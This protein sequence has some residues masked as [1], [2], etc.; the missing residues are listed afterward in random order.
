MT[1]SESLASR[2]AKIWGVLGGR[3]AKTARVTHV[4]AMAKR[5][6]NLMALKS[7]RRYKKVG[8]RKPFQF[9]GMTVSG[10]KVQVIQQKGKA[11]SI[12]SRKG[13]AKKHREATKLTGATYRQAQTRMLK[14]RGGVGVAAV[15]LGIG[16]HKGKKIQKERKWRKKYNAMQLAQHR[17]Q[18]LKRRP[19]TIPMRDRY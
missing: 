17:A 18:D 15:G 14:A 1:L 13:W 12:G 8:P 11:R 3:V 19:S 7:M 6:E 2:A 9:Q 4:G 10:G 5:R 16:G